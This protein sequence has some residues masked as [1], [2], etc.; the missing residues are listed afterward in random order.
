M[1][2]N[3][4]VVQWSGLQASTCQGPGVESLAGELRPHKLLGQKATTTGNV[5]GLDLRQVLRNGGDLALR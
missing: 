3:S 4:L 1:H 2:W 5:H